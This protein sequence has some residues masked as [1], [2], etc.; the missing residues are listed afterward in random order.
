[1]VRKSIS[2][3]CI[4]CMVVSGL[5]ASVAAQESIALDASL[6]EDMDSL[7]LIAGMGTPSN[8]R[9]WTKNEANLILSRVDRTTLTGVAATVYDNLLTT[10]SDGLAFQFKDGFQFGVGIDLYS[11]GYYH[12]NSDDFILEDDWIR[13]FEQRNPVFRLRFDFGLKD[14]LFIYSDLQYGQ[15]RFNYLDTYVSIA[16]QYPNGIGSII[17][18]AAPFPANLGGYFVTHSANYSTAF[19]TNSMPFNESYNIDFQTPKRA[20]ATVGGDS[21]NLTLARDKVSWGNGHS[22]NFIID[23]HVDYQEFAR[24]VVFSDYFKY[25]WLNVFFETNPTTGEDVDNFFRI[26]MA[27]RLEFRILDKLTFALSENVMFQNDFID[28]R[29][30]NPA[31]IYHNLNNRSMFN[32]IAHVELD[33][34]FAKG[35]N[36]YAQY[37]LDQ[38]QAPNESAAQADATGYLAGLEY[39]M[40]A[41]PGILTT[42][43]EFAQTSPALY[44]RDI[45]DFLMFRK[46]FTHGYPAGP[47]YLLAIDYIGYQYGGDMQVLQWDAAYRIPAV[48]EFKLALIGM[49]H[50]EVDY[51]TPNDVVN[52]TRVPTPSGDEVDETL[53]VSLSG[54]YTIPK[55]INWVEASLY[56][57]LDWIG[58]R[59]L[60]KATGLHS[61]E[62]SDLQ[63]TMGLAI[64]L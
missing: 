43:L 3:I 41:G 35:F 38:A 15:N 13:G 10:L 16:T 30:L 8:A 36:A 55:I 46:Y 62:T 48:A 19:H 64:S 49:R 27:H 12:T 14:Y 22:G 23:D 18:G 51:F 57:Q 2:L 42:S 61:N 4:L 63:L 32:A 29:Y 47:G 50:G 28:L 60:M 25:D 26:L 24:V 9:P 58:R 17:H 34:S 7:Y 45:V 21:W 1:M 31:F 52:A 33:Y 59:T 53:V 44:R 5:V 20:V 40:P 37:V 11:E 39:A 56:A 54:E 6:Y